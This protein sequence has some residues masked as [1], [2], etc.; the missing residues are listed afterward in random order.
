M[1]AVDGCRAGL[2]TPCALSFLSTTTTRGRI[3]V[4]SH[5][6]LALTGVMLPLAFGVSQKTSTTLVR[7]LT[8]K[9]GRIARSAKAAAN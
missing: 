3:R 6:S 5:E 1:I 4:H 2:K 9:I 7:R 8:K